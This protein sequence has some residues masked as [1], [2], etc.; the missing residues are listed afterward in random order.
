MTLGKEQRQSLRRE[1]REIREAFGRI[2]GTDA[3]SEKKRKELRQRYE[4]IDR[5]LR[6]ERKRV[7]KQ[8]R[9]IWED[10]ASLRAD[11]EDRRDLLLT[12]YRDLFHILRK[13]RPNQGSIEPGSDE[14]IP[15]PEDLV[16]G[17]Q[18]P[19]SEVVFDFSSFIFS[20]EANQAYTP[21]AAFGDFKPEPVP[22]SQQQTVLARVTPDQAPPAKDD[23]FILPSYNESAG[24]P[25]VDQKD[26]ED[27]LGLAGLSLSDILGNAGEA[28][29]A[30]TISG[31]IDVPD[32][33]DFQQSAPIRAADK[34]GTEADEDEPPN[35]RDL[36]E[37][38]PPVDEQFIAVE[39]GVDDP[40]APGKTTGSPMDPFEI[41]EDDAGILHNDPVAPELPETP[42]DIPV[43][44]PAEEPSTAAPNTDEQ[45]L[46]ARLDQAASVMDEYVFAPMPELDL[47]EDRNDVVFAPASNG[48]GNGHHERHP[49]PFGDAAV[50]SGSW[51]MA[52]EEAERQRK[53]GEIRS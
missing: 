16:S 26:K 38:E 18:P 5:I 10:F 40:D 47:E 25:V 45:D 35:P 6:E 7:L 14:D 32:I 31:D 43:D 27:T 29:L 2:W 12:Q 44:I 49:D 37:I 39:T 17:R 20:E 3:A 1:A 28:D 11:Q 42:E 24:L 51:D 48:N 52:R 36:E 19:G 41:E 34:E 30:P 22:Q 53:Q 21:P 8:C 50:D 15:T 13:D 23:G 46:Q 33:G 4:D 9:D